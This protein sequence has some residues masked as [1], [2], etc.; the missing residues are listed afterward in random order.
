MAAKQ[1]KLHTLFLAIVRGQQDVTMRQL[2]VMLECQNRPRT[3]RDL[4]EKLN[5]PKPAVTRIADRLE[6]FK[7]AER[8]P[9]GEDRRSIYLRLTSD[10]ATFAQ[11]FSAL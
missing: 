2:V 10:G 11:Q 9:D 6:E 7:F 5:I 1:S 4:A 8:V 3:V